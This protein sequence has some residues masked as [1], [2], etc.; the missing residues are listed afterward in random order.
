MRKKGTWLAKPKQDDN[1][2]P[3]CEWKWS[4]WLHIEE[5]FSVLARRR[6]DEARIAATLNRGFGQAS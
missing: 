3:V 5:S 4:A 2:R 6:E 1:K